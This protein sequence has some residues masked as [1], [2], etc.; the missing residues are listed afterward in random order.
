[1]TIKKT[2]GDIS[3]WWKIAWAFVNMEVVSRKSRCPLVQFRMGS[4]P[5]FLPGVRSFKPL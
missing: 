4:H 3:S 2:T 1:M 5:N